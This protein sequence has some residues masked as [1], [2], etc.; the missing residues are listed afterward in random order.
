MLLLALT[1]YG[2]KC[3]LE[4]V[5]NMPSDQLVGQWNIIMHLCMLVHEM[6]IRLKSL[7]IIVCNLI[8]YVITHGSYESQIL[9]VSNKSQWM[10]SLDN[11][12]GLHYSIINVYWVE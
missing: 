6:K 2:Y 4:F 11:L 7:T 9:V 10:I 3:K 8:V 5:G 1:L 12:S